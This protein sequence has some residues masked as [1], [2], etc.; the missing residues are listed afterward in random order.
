MILTVSDVS[1]GDTLRIRW[2]PS[3][4][5]GYSMRRII[6]LRRIT[7]RIRSDNGAV[8][9]TR[10]GVATDERETGYYVGIRDAHTLAPRCAADHI[11]AGSRSVGFD[12]VSNACESRL[13]VPQL[14]R[15]RY[16]AEWSDRL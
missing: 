14:K 4:L 7:T 12:C 16:S 13:R 11:G 8:A 9:E 6:E 5:P 15:S 2:E 1:R 3:A 10:A